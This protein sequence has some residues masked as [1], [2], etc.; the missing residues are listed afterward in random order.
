[1]V[2]SPNALRWNGRAG[3]YEV[4]Y[5]T[6][7]DP[8]TG[9][10]VWIRY[11]M[12]APTR[13]STQPGGCSLWFLTMDPRSGAKPVLGRKATYPLESMR[14]GAAPFELRIN[15][16]VCTDSGMK[17]AF[18]DVSWDLHWAP[19]DQ[20][21]EPIRPI[22]H[23]LGLA[24]TAF[25]LPHADLSIDGEIAFAGER[26]QL[27]GARGGQAHLWGSKHARSWAWTHCSE[28]RTLEGEW[29]DGEFIDGV[30]ATVPRFG[31]ELGPN[32]PIVGCI[33]GKDFR[34]TSPLRILGNHSTYTL[35]S[36]R[37]EAVDGPRKLIGEVT[38]SREQLAGVTYHDPDGEPA[39]CYNT[40]TASL[41]LHVYERASQVGGWAHRR[42]LLAPGRAHFEYAQRAPVPGLELLIH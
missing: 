14:A 19:C 24:D 6:L 42:T 16:A 39:Y 33:A 1:M 10:G 4:Y 21:Y 40:E 12:V 8:R 26:A 34:S 38:A 13:G 7:T 35:T 20:A 2:S 31:R 9:L 18:E 5:L 15:D 23:R 37:F 36:W 30:S 28:L 3:H 11:T 32:T 29:M 41:R 17:G 27:S 25:V 22:L